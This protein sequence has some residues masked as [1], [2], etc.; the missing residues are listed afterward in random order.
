MIRKKS[1]MKECKMKSDLT[2][3]INKPYQ[4]DPANFIHIHIQGLLLIIGQ[5]PNTKKCASIAI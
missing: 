3:E 2:Q 1:S 5:F 4:T